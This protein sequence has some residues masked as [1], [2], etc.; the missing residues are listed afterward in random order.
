MALKHAILASLLDGEAS[1]Y[2]LSKRMD[3]SVAN[4]WH[5]V[6]TQLYAE[7]RRLE[8]ASLISGRDVE[9][10]RRP[11]KRVFSLTEKGRDELVDFTRVPAPPTAIKDDLLVKVQ[12]ADVGDL[13]SVAAKLDER[14]KAA[15]AQLAVLEALIRDFLRGRDE[16]T[17]L[18]TARRVGPYLNLRRGRDFLRE[19]I[20][21]YRWSAEALRRRAAARRPARLAKAS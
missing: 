10:E 2:E 6:P 5:V 8:Q 9:Q 15:E 19:S 4:F 14:R 18:A 7:L 21:W 3:I 17:F 16:E 1:G 11:N 12:V 13:P 20:A